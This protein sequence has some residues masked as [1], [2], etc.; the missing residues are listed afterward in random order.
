MDHSHWQPQKEPKVALYIS[1]K[2]I[3]LT[4]QLGL[5]FDL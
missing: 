3:S 5:M 4:V 2:V 1:R